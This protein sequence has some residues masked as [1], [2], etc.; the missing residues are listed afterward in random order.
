LQFNQRRLAA[1]A[2]LIISPRSSRPVVVSRRRRF[3]AKR[4]TPPRPRS[5][6]ARNNSTDESIVARAPQTA[7]DAT[8]ELPQIP[9]PGDVADQAQR[10]ESIVTDVIE[11]SEE[12][13]RL[14]AYLRFLERGGK[15]G[16]HFDDWLAAERD[17]KTRKG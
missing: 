8:E 7:T 17:L 12:D 16:S 13:I 2:T 3:M 11:P 4:S 1:F 10:S 6:A 14:R 15:D 5:R 9:E